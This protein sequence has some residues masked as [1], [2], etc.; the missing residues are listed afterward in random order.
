MPVTVRWVDAAETQ[1]A[2]ETTI[3]DI[4]VRHLLDHNKLTTFKQI[5]SQIAAVLI[6]CGLA[7]QYVTPAPQPLALTTAKWFVNRLPQSGRWC[8]QLSRPGGETLWF[9]GAPETYKKAGLGYATETCPQEV[10]E[11]YARRWVPVFIGQ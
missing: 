7:T 3:M 10:I 2:E 5:D 11:D 9:T 4:T 1:T 6:A 8:I